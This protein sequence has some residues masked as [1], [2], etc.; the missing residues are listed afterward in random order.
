MGLS[1]YESVMAAERIVGKHESFYYIGS[2]FDVK[3]LAESVLH[4]GVKI[5][6]GFGTTSVT[7]REESG[8]GSTE[9]QGFVVRESGDELQMRDLTGKVTTFAKSRIVK[10]SAIPGSMM[11]EGLADALTLEDFR[12]LTSYLEALKVT[13]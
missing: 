10:R 6:Q 9:Y 12:A 3:Y 1:F 7:A 13:K 4:P 2:K 5:A 8:K 11:P